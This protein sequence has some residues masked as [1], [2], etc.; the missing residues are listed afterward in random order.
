MAIAFSHNTKSTPFSL[1]RS[2]SGF[3]SLSLSRSLFFAFSPAFSLSISS[4]LLRSSSFSLSL[5]PSASL[6]CCLSLCH[7]FFLS[8][9]ACSLSL[10][11]SCSGSVSLCSSLI[12]SLA[13]TP[14]LLSLRQ[15][16]THTQL[17]DTTDY[18]TIEWNKCIGCFIFK[19]CFPQKSPIIIGSFA[20]RDLQLK[21]SYKSSP[22]YMSISFSP[23]C[24]R[25]FNQLL[26]TH[27]LTHTHTQLLDTT[28]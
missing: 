6:S 22:L 7:S 13:H 26:P 21:A 19:G 8:L 16:H 10:S 5:L 24:S 9:F 3:L 11:L 2:R 1:T 23:T 17:L 4:Y 14:S 15:T 25:S 12:L 20:E 18:H 28:H 27:S